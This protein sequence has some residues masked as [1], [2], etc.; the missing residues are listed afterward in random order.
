[1]PFFVL[2]NILQDFK[3]ELDFIGDW[4]GLKV[5]SLIWPLRISAKYTKTVTQN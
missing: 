5:S 4:S 3:F 1:M 2:C